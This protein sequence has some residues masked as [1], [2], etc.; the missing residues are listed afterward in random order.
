MTIYGDGDQTR[1]FINVKDVARANYLA[2]TTNKSTGVYNLGSGTSITINK[3]AEMM[4]EISGINVGIKYAPVRS[5]DVRHCKAQINK[6][7]NELGF[8]PSVMLDEGLKEYMNWFKRNC[9]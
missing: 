3:L 5:A 8:E 6:I 4:Q 7:K 1:D 9:I 2:G